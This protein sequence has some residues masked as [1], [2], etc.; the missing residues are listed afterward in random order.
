MSKT[1][2]SAAPVTVG[3]REL[4]DHLS[5]YLDDV[6]AGGE[7]VVTERGRPVARLIPAE[8][9]SALERLV[10]AGIVTP[11]IRP[12]EPSSSFGRIHTRGD[13]LQFVLDQRR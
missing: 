5:A 2:H 11:P 12:R 1:P 4:R 6:K 10:A 9:G 13:L 8:G 3:V 7:L